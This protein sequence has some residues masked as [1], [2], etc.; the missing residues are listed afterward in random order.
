MIPQTVA[1]WIRPDELTCLPEVLVSED[2]AEFDAGLSGLQVFVCSD[3]SHVNTGYLICGLSRM[4][5]SWMKT[6]TTVMVRGVYW[7]YRINESI[8]ITLEADRPAGMPKSMDH[9]FQP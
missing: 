7:N 2:G 8:W 4:I 1:V 5:R 6:I 3:K 9:G